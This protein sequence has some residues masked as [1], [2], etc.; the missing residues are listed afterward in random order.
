MWGLDLGTTNTTLGRWDAERD[1]PQLVS[2]AGLE[3]PL[4]DPERAAPP[5][6]LIPS[7]T[8]LIESPGAWARFASSGLFARRLLSGRLAYIGQQALERSDPS[9]PRGFVPSFKGALGREPLRPLTQG[10]GRT[11]SARDIA[12]HFVR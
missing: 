3:R 10:G 12:W 6:G 8:Q 2:L 4:E 1:R 9:R 5:R 11:H 7:A